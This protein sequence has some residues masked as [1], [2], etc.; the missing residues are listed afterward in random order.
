MIPWILLFCCY[1]IICWLTG[2]LLERPIIAAVKLVG[3]NSTLKNCTIRIQSAKCGVN[4]TGNN[5]KV[6]SCFLYTSK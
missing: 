3:P 2:L 4:V 1:C 5:C 6:I